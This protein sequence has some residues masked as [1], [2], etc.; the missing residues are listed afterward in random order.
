[1]VRRMREL[2]YFVACSVDGFIARTN[3]S[4]DFFPMEGE[5]L[6][7]LVRDYPETI[8]THLRTELGVGGAN[9]HFDTV[10]MGRNTYQV[11]V[12][13]GVTNPYGHLR[14]YLFSRTLASSPD[15]NVQLVST[16]PLPFVR[17]LKQESGLDI[18]LCGG[19]E[20]AAALFPE[21]DELILKVNPVVI[22]KGIPLFAREVEATALRL[23]SSKV[24]SHGFM[25]SRFRKA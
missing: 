5:H 17:A 8:P 11:G 25:L 6:A 16:D 19:A 7:D 18:W 4:F 3:G 12:N 23:I 20:L 1:M 2:K 13:V 14:Q 21:I 24:Y 10:V 22:G 15:P 9:R